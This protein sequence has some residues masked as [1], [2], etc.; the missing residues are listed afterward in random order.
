MG[1]TALKVIWFTGSSVCTALVIGTSTLNAC[2]ALVRDAP[3][4]DPAPNRALENERNAALMDRDAALRKWKLTE[5]RAATLEGVAAQLEL[6][7]DTWRRTA[8]LLPQKPTG[9][10]NIAPQNLPIPT[11]IG[12]EHRKDTQP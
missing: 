7:L 12:P 10:D 9:A 11:A 8:V 6:E 4:P 2:V 5:V 3:A 1:W